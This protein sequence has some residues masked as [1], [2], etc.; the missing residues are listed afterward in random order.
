MGLNKKTF[1]FLK[2]I[3]KNNDRDW[4]A[5]NKPRYEEARQDFIAV[6]DELI[7]TIG[8][9]DPKIASLD[10]KKAV[11]RIYKDTRF[12]KDKTPYKT[13]MGAHL[14][15]HHEKV[16]DRAGYY[17]HIE[18]GN[19]FLAGGAYLPPGPWIKAIRQ[20]IDYNAADLKKIINSKSF[21]SYFGEIE[22]D[23]LKTAPRDYP[24][25]HPEIELLKYKSFL[26]VHKFSEKE[27]LSDDFSKY[28]GKVFKA[29]QPFD[30]F[31]NRG[32]VNS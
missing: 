6:V 23:K 32:L 14:V 28:A 29:I 22:G 13:N 10:A 12:S 18:P 30:E 17:I 4:F 9:F 16:H 3:K 11:F 2:D 24:K 31:L 19:C 1:Q 21:K 25:D 8:K 20:E 26:A 27:I 15:A 7:T 5:A